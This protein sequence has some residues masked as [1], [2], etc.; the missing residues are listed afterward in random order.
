MEERAGFTFRNVVEYRHGKYVATAPISASSI[1]DMQEQMTLPDAEK[2]G[3]FIGQ[4]WG[5]TYEH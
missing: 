5:E 3:R 1:E 2:F 4:H